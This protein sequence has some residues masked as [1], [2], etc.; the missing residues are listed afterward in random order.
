VRLRLRLPAQPAA[1][2]AQRRQL[3][4]YEAQAAHQVE[5]HKIGDYTV[6]K[7]LGVGTFGRVV[8][9]AAPSGQLAAIKLLP[10]GH[11]V[12]LHSSTI[13]RPLSQLVPAA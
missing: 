13:A 11:Y 3:A 7:T 4:V 12:S 6:L 10:R 5:E 2:A 1:A 9:A 8:L